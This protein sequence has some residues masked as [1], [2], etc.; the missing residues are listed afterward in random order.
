MRRE[1]NLFGFVK[2]RISLVYVVRE[3]DR[4]KCVEAGTTVCVKMWHEKGGKIG[5]ICKK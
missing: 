4:T 1:V 3:R 5:I 2:Q